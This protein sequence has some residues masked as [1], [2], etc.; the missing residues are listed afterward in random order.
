M[1]GAVTAWVGTSGGAASRVPSSARSW[2]ALATRSSGAPVISSEPAAKCFPLASKGFSAASILTPLSLYTSASSETCPVLF[3]ATREPVP[4]SF[5]ARAARVFHGRHA[6]L[7]DS[8]IG[9][10]HH[11]HVE[12]MRERPARIVVRMFLWIVRRPELAIEQCIGDT[13]VRLIHAHHKAACC[14]RLLFRFVS[15]LLAGQCAGDGCGELLYLD[16]LPF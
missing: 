10:A 6:G 12:K 4:S 11:L 14:K 16:V 15:A 3:T 5:P 13:R 7:Q 1:R 9:N 8:H 2:S